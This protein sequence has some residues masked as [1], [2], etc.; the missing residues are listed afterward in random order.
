MTPKHES[1]IGYSGFDLFEECYGY[2]EDACYIADTEV[3]AHLFMRVATFG[4]EYRIEPVTLSQIMNDYG[5][6]SGEFAMENEALAR[7][8]TAASAAGIQF[9]TSA[10]DIGPDLTLVNVEGVKIHHDDD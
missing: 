1:I 6:S 10:D 9:E 3:S 4:Q 7:F 2:N 5:Y 8:R